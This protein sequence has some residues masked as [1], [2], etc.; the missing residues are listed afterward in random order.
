MKAVIFG[1]GMMYQRNS[2]WIPADDI[3][4][5]ID[6]DPKKQGSYLNGIQINAPEYILNISYDKIV[7]MS[8]KL[9]EMKE[10]LLDMGISEDSIWSWKHYKYECLRGVLRLY[11]YHKEQGN[12]KGRIL[13]ISQHLRYDG[14]AIAAVHA[15]KALQ[16]RKYQVVLAAPS[17]DETFI[18]EMSGRGGINIIICPVICYSDQTDL[19]WIKQFD[20][21]IVN[22][23]P[24]MPCACEISKFKPVLWW[25]HEV[26][27]AYEL[28]QKEFPQYDSISAM[29]LINIAAVSTVAKRNFEEH[30]PDR[31]NHILPYGIPDE[32]ISSFH[33]EK[34]H[35]FTFA[36]IGAIEE[37][38]AQKLFVEA[39]TYFSKEELKDLE[40]LII[41]MNHADEYYRE[42]RILADEVPQIK[43]TGQLTREEMKKIYQKIDVVVCASMEETMSIVITEGMMYEKVCITTKTTG[44]AEYITNGKNGFVCRTGDAKSL[45]TSMK[46]IVEHRDQLQS[47]RNC[48][49]ETY[50]EHF[51]MES[52]GERLEKL[53]V[54]T[55]A[56]RIY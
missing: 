47:I 6:N 8:A 50:L 25:L 34:T 39:V 33:K 2:A 46:W 3:V 37:R 49:R 51:S 43:M 9:Q 17:G 52:F 42:V 40:F 12:T 41:G 18:E 26:K 56:E 7:L 48:A 53:I 23:F 38:K 16:L 29:K 35:K 36:I 11:C 1:T 13:I 30:Y 21:A 19:Y 20:V 5:F 10:Q 28:T 32:Y 31:V 54:E 27:A 24:M 22:V 55:K 45:W 44:I 4:A 15:V 14:A